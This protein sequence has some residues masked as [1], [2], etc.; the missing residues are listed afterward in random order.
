MLEAISQGLGGAEGEPAAPVG[1]G[2]PRDAQGRFTF[3]DAAGNAVDAQGNPDPTGAKAA[4]GAQQVAQ[5][6]IAD[7]DITKMPEGLQPKAQER[8]HKLASTNREL[9]EK[10]DQASRQVEYVREAFTQHGVQQEQFEQAVNFIGMLNKGD[11]AGA[12]RFLSEQL[13]QISLMTGQAPNVDPLAG[14]PDLRQQ[15]DALLIAPDSAME[16]ARLRASQQAQQ[17]HSQRQQQAQAQEQ[18]EQQ[19]QQQAQQVRVKATQDVDGFCKQMAASDLDYSAIEAKLLP[20]LSTLLEGVP[21]QHW[22]GKVK[23]QYQL[24]KSMAGSMKA[25]SGSP[26]GQVLRPTG[27][28]SPAAQPKTMFEA[29]F[30]TG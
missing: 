27:Q 14:F 23:A 9:T 21:P 1:G 8:F 20:V 3:K 18:Q 2:Q 7:D 28:A 6:P 10:L 29:M 25:P 22:A 30:G 17:Q 4:D 24:L 26:S 5:P 16:M 19:A 11:L 13:Q 12:Q 15:V